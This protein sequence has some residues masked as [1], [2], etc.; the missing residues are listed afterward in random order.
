MSHR[1]TKNSRKNLAQQTSYM[2]VQ[3]HRAESSKKNRLKIWEKKLKDHAEEIS[4]LREENARLRD[5]IS[6]AHLSMSEGDDFGGF[7]ILA[8]ALKERPDANPA[9]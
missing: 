5:V 6:A 7:Q 8:A 1:G 9:D 4:R 3:F 2:R